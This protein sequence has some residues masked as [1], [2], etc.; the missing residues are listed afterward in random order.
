MSGES[1]SQWV[2]WAAGWCVSGKF[3]QSVEDLGV[4]MDWESLYLS[5]RWGN[6]DVEWGNSG[7]D[8][9]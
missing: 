8:G 9:D 7:V 1:S 2:I 6:S 5:S 4:G 3:L